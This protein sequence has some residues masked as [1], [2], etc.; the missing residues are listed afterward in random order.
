MKA[1]YDVQPEKY[2]DNKNGSATYRWGI[3]QVEITRNMGGEDV[4]ET[5]WTADEVV[6]WGPVTR[7]KIVETVIAEVW[8]V[9]NEAKLLNDYNAAV[10]GLLTSEYQDHYIAFLTERKALKELINDDCADLN[11]L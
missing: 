3:E 5:K 10:N 9:N 6:V 1:F 8:G 2:S 11:I 7:S 4:T